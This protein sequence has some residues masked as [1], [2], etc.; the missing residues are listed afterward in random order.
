MPKNRLAL[1]KSPY[2]LQHS[3][4]PVDWYPWGDEAFDKARM[5]KKPIFLS[6]GYSTCHWCHVMEKESFEDPEVAQLMNEAFVSIKVDREERPDLDSIYMTASQMMTGA[7]G[8]PLNIIL[9]PDKRPFYALT[10]IPKQSRFGMMGM[11]E[12]I[13]RIREAWLTRQD[14]VFTA[15]NHAI[16]ALRQ[17]VTA[18]K[19]EELGKDVLAAA[20]QELSRRFDEEHGG[21]SYAPKFPSPHNILF[22]LRYWNRTKDQ[23]ALNMAEKTLRG[24]RTGGIYDQLGFGFH[25]YSTD[26]KWLM[27]HFEKMIY[28]QGMLAMAY[29]EAFQVTGK[30]EYRETAQEIFTYALREMTSTEGGFYSGEDADSEGKEGKFYLWTEDEIRQI[31]KK[32]EADLIMKVFNVE[33]QGNFTEQGTEVRTG[34]NILHLKKT[35][36]ELATELNIPVQ[37][38]D[39]RL[40]KGRLELFTARRKRVNPHK[41]DKILADWNGLLIAAF[42]KGARVFDKPEYAEAAKKAM[43]FILK[44]MRKPDGRLLHRYR[45]GE[46]AI[47]AYLD[48]Y[49][50]LIWGLLEIYET[51]FDVRYLQDALGLNAD[52]LKHFWDD[53][54]GGFYFA[55]D[56]GEELIVRKKEIYDGA[57]PSGNSVAMLNLLRL[58]RITAYPAL[59]E[60]AAEIG[61]AFSREV[62]QSPSVYTHL[63]VAVDFAVGPSYEVVIAGD[64]RADDSKEMLKALSKPYIPNKIVL[65]RPTEQEEPDIT[66]IAPFTKNQTSIEGKATAY[67]CRNYSCENPTTDINEMLELLKYLKID[68]PLSKAQK[69]L[70]DKGFQ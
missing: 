27:P 29:A 67:T 48:D 43:D 37:D 41:D 24:M 44:N 19:G 58:G 68:I 35:V 66:D 7:G 22:L 50:F 47:T 20:Y 5:E 61:R 10:Y 64:S 15:A 40:E 62:R 38:L 4:N 49:A 32:E 55:P 42:A 45:D 69:P 36:A 54:G 12:L 2:L 6:I 18:G 51:T 56:D 9:T 17:T 33:R 39:M 63:M 1:E 59:E 26:S 70:L 8:W 65:L 34:E 13:P 11:L 52:L 23:D 16:T 30:K 3:E 28:D 57:I 14:D 21:F 53:R 25:R 60:K 46:A 31:L